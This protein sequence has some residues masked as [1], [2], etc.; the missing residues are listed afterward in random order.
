MSITSLRVLFVS[1]AY[2]VGVNQGK[3]NAIAEVEGVEVG[4]LVPSNW[5]AREWN[6]QMPVER[7]Y[8]KIHIYSAPVLFSGRGGAHIYNPGKIWQVLT[9]F[10]PDI[11]QVEEEVFS[12]CTF[13][14]AILMRLINKHLIVFGWENMERQL[15]YFRWLT[16]QFVLNTASFLLPGNQD[17][18]KIMRQWGYKGL[19]EVMPQI[20]VDTN[21]FTTDL[22]KGDRQQF[23]IGFLGRLVPEKGIDLL[24]SS[25]YQLKDR[26]VEC[27]LIICGSGSQETE[28]RQ[29]AK[30]LQIED[31]I[32]WKGS[33]RHEE[34]PAEISQFDVLVLPSR[35]ISTW[36][37]QF[38]HVLIEAMAMGIP[39]IGSTCGEI[40]NVIQCDNL[41]F[42]EEDTQELTTILERMILDPNWRQEMAHHGIDMVHKNYSHQK[43]A[44][45]LIN[46]WQIANK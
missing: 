9:D 23:N 5:K 26:G 20:G 6:R 34:A 29:Q 31:R 2:V 32:T 28:L 3:L 38:G 12:L 30:M 22:V 44:E 43:I 25:V 33:I 27:Q 41:I 1:H 14:V 21:L 16:C 13:E 35:T 15:P 19:L 39:V 42:Q 7:P 18:A 17:G 4:L 11:V 36:K 8:P 40:S 37:E 10:Q 45:R 46:L 24:L